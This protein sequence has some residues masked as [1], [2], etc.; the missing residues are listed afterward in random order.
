MI[1]YIRTIYKFIVGENDKSNYNRGKYTNEIDKE[2]MKY[3]PDF[4]QESD[5]EWIYEL[6]IGNSISIIFDDNCV[7]VYL[8]TGDEESGYTTFLHSENPT[9]FTLELILDRFDSTRIRDK[10]IDEILNS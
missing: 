2:S 3:F 9:Y 8:S 1:K 6:S 5:D 7:R 10:K 4:I